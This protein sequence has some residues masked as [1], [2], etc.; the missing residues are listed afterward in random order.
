LALPSNL[1]IEEGSIRP[2]VVV[3]VRARRRTRKIAPLARERGQRAAHSKSSANRPRH[4]PTT[5]NE[6]P[7]QEDPMNADV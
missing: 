3:E 6:R 1:H 4:A 2:G 7:N 5:R